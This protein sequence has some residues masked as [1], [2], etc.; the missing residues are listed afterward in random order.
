LVNGSEGIA[1]GFAQKILPRNPINIIRY[2]RNKLNG[3]QVFSQDLEPWFNGFTG[4]VQRGEKENQ[5]IIK[6][7]A[8]KI[9]LTRVH[10]TEIPPKYDLKSYIEFLDNLEDKKIIRSFKD[11]S[12]DDVFTFRDMAFSGN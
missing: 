10:V 9:G 1:T 12:V 8:Q 6:G 3:S 7:K 11:K 2:I 4:T 5:Y